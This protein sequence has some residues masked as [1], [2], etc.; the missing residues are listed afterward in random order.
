MDGLGGYE[1]KMAKNSRELDVILQGLIDEH[2]SNSKKGLMGN[3]TMIDH[4][5]SLQKSEPEYYTDQIIKGVTMN[6]VFAGTDTAAVT[7]EWAMSLLLNHPDVLKKA[8]VE[9]DTCVGQERLL[10][11]A[12]LP[13]LHY[14]QNIISETFRLCPPAPLWL[15]HMSSANCQLGGFD[16]PRD[17]MLLVNSWTL[18]RDPK[19]WDDPTS[20]K[21]ER[22]EGGERGETYKLLPFGTGRRACPGSGLANKVVGLTLGSLIQCY[23]WERISE[24]KVDMMEGKG[25]TMPKM[26]PLEAMCSAYEILKNV[27]QDEETMVN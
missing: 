23:E 16:I 1:K 15:P 4:L 13:K 9:L 27:L 20:F 11:E 7:M 6:L 2:R 5:L 24:K 3:N 22:F 14:L 25:L 8:K 12:D 26:E 17:A 19:L 21:P 10:E 18:H